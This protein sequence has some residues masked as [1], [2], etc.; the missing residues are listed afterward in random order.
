[1]TSTSSSTAPN[2]TS[3]RIVVIGAGYVGM[4]AAHQLQRKLSRG[5]AEITVID[6]Q[7]YMTYQPFLPETAAGNLEPRHVVVSLRRLLR[8]CELINARVTGVNHSQRTVYFTSLAG[9]QRELNYTTLVVCPGSIVR[10]LPIPGL[11]EYGIGIKTVGE[12]VWLR[13]HILTQ[14]D[15]AASTGD[16]VVRERALTFMV[17]GG[18]YAGV[19]TLAELEDL[20]RIVASHYTKNRWSRLLPNELRWVLVEATG[21]ILPEVGEQM[22]RYTVELLRKRG[23]DVRLET[24]LESVADGVAVLSDGTRMPTSTLIWTAGVKANPMLRDTDLPL[25]THG[26]LPTDTYLRVSD[27]TNVWSAGDCAA[28]P[29]LTGGEGAYCAPS[30]QHAIR[31]AKRLAGNI[32]ATLRGTKL[33][34][35]RHTYAGSVAGLG[36]HRGVAQIY[37]VKLSGLP[38]WLLHRVYHLAMMP[39]F[40]RKVR[41]LLDWTVS[42]FFKRDIVALGEIH[43]PREEFLRAAAESPAP[44]PAPPENILSAPASSNGLTETAKA[45]AGP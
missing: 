38:A 3:P 6:P 2:T 12:A 17:V 41:I 29:D 31:Q 25:D 23:I 4:Y 7:S 45:H 32:V 27:T 34:E 10:T 28:V 8:R 21:R 19:E 35:Y 26:R 22:G 1:M 5:E 24:R 14:L 42:L 18:G 33:K 40:N 15:I 37:G 39:T 43:E 16:P 20:S 11:A 44:L 9:E 36:L 13:N 30:A